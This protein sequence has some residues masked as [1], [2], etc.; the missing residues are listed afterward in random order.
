[1]G[2]SLITDAASLPVTLADITPELLSYAQSVENDATVTRKLYEATN[3]F[4]NQTCR[5]LIS[6]TWMQTFN[7]WPDPT[8]DGFFAFKINRVPLIS[9]ASVKYY[10]LNGTQQTV[11]ASDYWPSTTCI[12]PI[13]AFKPTSFIWPPLE[14][15]RPD[16]IEVRYTAGYAN[17][18]AVPDAI[19]L[20]IKEL[21][22]YWYE[23]REA[24]VVSTSAGPT[25]TTPALGEIPYGVRQI[26][27]DYN[28]SGYT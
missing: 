12:P 28:A 3:Y 8:C 19:K 22:A 25:A 21:A 10:D 4:Q 14:I 7:D 13:V 6:A 2:I 23:Q 5:Q 26:I 15:G 16:S 18:A 9:I 1:M 20:A 24:V 17:A 11:S 27:A